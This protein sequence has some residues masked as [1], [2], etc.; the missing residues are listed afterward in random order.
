MGVR[1]ASELDARE[2]IVTSGEFGSARVEMEATGARLR[3]RLAGDERVLV[4]PGFVGASAEGETTTLGRGGSDLTASVLGVELSP[5]GTAAIFLRLHD[6][7]VG[8]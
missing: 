2:V 8:R 7:A 6:I 3:K 1:D 5:N 4:V